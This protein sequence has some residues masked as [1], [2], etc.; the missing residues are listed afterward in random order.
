MLRV[1]LAS[2]DVTEVCAIVRRG[3]GIADPKLREV[4]H[5]NYGDFTAV[6]PAFSGIDACFYCLGKSVRQTSG[7]AEYRQITYDYALAAAGALKAQSPAAS[8]HFISGSGAHLQSRFMWA[9]VKAE[10]ERDLIARFNAVCYRPAAID[11]IPSSSE[12]MGYKLFR[13]VS[14]VVLKPFRS[15]YVTGDDIGRAML[16]VK[17]DG[18]R[19]RVIENAEIRD[20]AERRHR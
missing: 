11:G 13:P 15:L 1:C 20:R 16:Q 12:P 2:P 18:T 8:F 7:E 19:G 14:R 10:T 9:R 3:L 6:A 17:A 5:G 4:V